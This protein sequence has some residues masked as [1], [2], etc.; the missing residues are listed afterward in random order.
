[1]VREK[2][3]LGVFIFKGTMSDPHQ[4]NTTNTACHKKADLDF[5]KSEN[6]SDSSPSSHTTLTNLKGGPGRD[7]N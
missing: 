1:M 6:S 7:E 5:Q 4:R 2:V 3:A